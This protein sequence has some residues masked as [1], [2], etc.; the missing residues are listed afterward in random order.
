MSVVLFF[1]VN[2]FVPKRN[3]YASVAKLECEKGMHTK[4]VI[5]RMGK[6]FEINST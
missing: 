2:A 3:A 5:R 1:I 4:C 6:L